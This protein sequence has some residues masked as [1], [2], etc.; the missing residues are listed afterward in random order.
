VHY[1]PVYL[2]SYYRQ[3]G[4]R[5]GLAPVAEMASSQLLTLPLFPAMTGEDVERVVGNLVKSLV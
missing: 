2:H 4:Y 1:A 3:R 5:A